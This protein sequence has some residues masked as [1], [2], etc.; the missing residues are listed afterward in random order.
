MGNT[1]QLG[2]PLV[3]PAQAQ[4][5]V[6]V[7]EA[8]AKLDALAQLRLTSSTMAAPPSEP[9]PGQSYY[10]EAEGVGAWAG[11]IG[12]IATYANGGWTFTRPLVGWRAWDEERGA[13]RTFDG[14]GWVDGGISVR[15]SGSAASFKTDEFDHFLQPG[16]TNATAY[17][18]PKNAVVF[19]VTGR[20]RAPFQGSGLVSWRLGVAESD[21][22]YGSGLGVGVNSYV[23]GL[24]ASPVSYYENTPLVLSAEGG[25]FASGMVSLSV[26]YLCLSVPREI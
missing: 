12:M 2:L 21:L 11:Q 26:H 25:E 18:L 4:K 16:P 17:A 5:H 15:S 20:V 1:V 8:F 24:T 9:K 13:F 3:M 7:N 23:L 22:R 6:T 19:G 10:V 14:I